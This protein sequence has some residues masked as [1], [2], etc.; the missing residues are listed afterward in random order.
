MMNGILSALTGRTA[1]FVGGTVLLMLTGTIC[2]LWATGDEV[3]TSLAIAWGSLAGVGIG[4]KI[5]SG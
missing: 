1:Q 2:Y 3:P 5:P 4:Y